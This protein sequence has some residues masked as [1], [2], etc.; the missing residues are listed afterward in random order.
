LSE[1][2]RQIIASVLQSLPPRKRV[3][4]DVLPSPV[5]VTPQ[6]A[7]NLALVINE[8]ATN[9]LKYGLAEQ[10]AVRITININYEGGSVLFE[11]KN[12]GPGYPPEVLKLKHHNVGLYLIQNIVTKGL[13]GKLSL[14]NDSG[15]IAT[16]RFPG[17]LA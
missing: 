8:L 1:L 7:N 14:R 12:N 2:A 13:R 9:T 5:R 16:I 17:S 4:V 3:L 15:A 10:K 6:Q 11:F